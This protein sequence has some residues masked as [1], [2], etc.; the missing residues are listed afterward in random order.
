MVTILISAILITTREV[1]ILPSFIC[2]YQVIL[3]VEVSIFNLLGGLPYLLHILKRISRQS[4]TIET[5]NHK[6][7]NALF[8][9]HFYF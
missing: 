1:Y 4:N 2:V 5:H 3:S 8:F 6:E 9:L 7:L